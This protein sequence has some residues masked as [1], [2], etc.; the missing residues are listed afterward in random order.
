M[1]RALPTPFKST[2]QVQM[3][4]I[5][6]IILPSI[7]DLPLQEEGRPRGSCMAKKFPPLTDVKITLFKE[8]S[9]NK[10]RLCSL[11]CGWKKTLKK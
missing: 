6:S 10:M 4:N 7:Q 1:N 11:N 2:L 5:Y 8:E 9:M 3:E